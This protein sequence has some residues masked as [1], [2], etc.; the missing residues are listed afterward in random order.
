PSRCVASPSTAPTTIRA[1][2]AGWDPETAGN[3]LA[4]VLQRAEIPFRVRTKSGQKHYQFTY[5]PNAPDP[6]G[7]H[8]HECAVI[9][10]TDGRFSVQCR[11]SQDATWGVFKSII[12]WPEHSRQVMRELGIRPRS[13]PY[14][15]TDDGLFYLQR[16][17]G[18]MRK[19][20]MT[21]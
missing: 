4:G 5:C 10:G 19:V 12:G 20:R 2:V 8:S 21:N 14:R 6:D 15:A 16:F 1:A 9:I 18:R 13:T 3:V 17:R 11:H 7:A